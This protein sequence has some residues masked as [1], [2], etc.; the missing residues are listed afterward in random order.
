[1]TTRRCGQVL[2]VKDGPFDGSGPIPWTV[3]DLP[4]GHDGSHH[5]VELASLEPELCEHCESDDHTEE[6]CLNGE[7]CQGKCNV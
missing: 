3:C 4:A 2:D 7:L 5:E 1:M 6:D